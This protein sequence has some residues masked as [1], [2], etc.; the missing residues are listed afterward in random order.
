MKNTGMIELVLTNRNKVL[1]SFDLEKIY[2]VE[3]RSRLVFSFT[4]RFPFVK[5]SK[6]PYVYFRYKTI[7]NFATSP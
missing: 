7:Y 3:E 2:N 4:Y 6:R 5:I 1:G